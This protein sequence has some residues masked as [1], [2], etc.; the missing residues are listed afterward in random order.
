M[1]NQSVSATSLS[2]RIEENISVYNVG[3]SPT[4]D[5]EMRCGF[6]ITLFCT[7]KTC[8]H[9][10]PLQI[11]YY[12]YTSSLHI[13]IFWM[14][15]HFKCARVL[16]PGGTS[17]CAAEFNQQFCCLSAWELRDK[18][19]LY[20]SVPLVTMSQG[21][22]FGLQMSLWELKPGD[23][24]RNQQITKQTQA[25]VFFYAFQTHIHHKHHAGFN[26]RIPAAV[27]KLQCSC[28]SVIMTRCIKK[29][30]SLDENVVFFLIDL[31]A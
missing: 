19:Q 29:G 3:R 10:N 28:I 4:M 21:A 23:L 24:V 16:T 15:Y 13:Y 14:E 9:Q 25:T 7:I 12:Y 31:R 2:L 26:Q 27:F 8:H 17:H 20:Q 22:I 6:I 11:I 5:G 18:Q 1:T 30:T